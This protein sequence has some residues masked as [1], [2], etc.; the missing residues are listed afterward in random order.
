MI[1]VTQKFN[2]HGLQ[3]LERWIYGAST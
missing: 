2:R 1:M 3:L